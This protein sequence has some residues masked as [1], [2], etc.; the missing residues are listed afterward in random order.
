LIPAETDDEEEQISEATMQ[1]NKIADDMWN[2]YQEVLHQQSLAANE[3]SNEDSGSD[4]GSDE[5]SEDEF[6]LWLKQQTILNLHLHLHT[7]KMC[8]NFFF[9][10]RLLLYFSFLY[11]WLLNSLKS[12]TWVVLS[13][14]CFTVS[15]SCLLALTYLAIYRYDSSS[16]WLI[17]NSI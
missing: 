1:W 17:S 15:D 11:L 5:E 10:L 14:T 2:Q 16:L 7:K 13:M 9:L 3:E 8:Y 6:Y 4:E 12:R